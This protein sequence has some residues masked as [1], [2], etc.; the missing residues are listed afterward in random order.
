MSTYHISGM[1][2][3][4]NDAI[5]EWTDKI[6]ENVAKDKNSSFEEGAIILCPHFQ[7]EYY[8]QIL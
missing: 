8:E 5:T 6:I 1:G 2:N 4:G 3:I 7:E